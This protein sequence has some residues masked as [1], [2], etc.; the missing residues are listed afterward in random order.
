MK[1]E[2]D[3]DACCIH[4]GLDA[5][6]FPRGERLPPC[7][8]WNEDTRAE[9]RRRYPVWDPLDLAEAEMLDQEQ[10]DFDD[11]QPE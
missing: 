3:H 6:D 10:P 9:N 2:L 1:H 8:V 4:C 7:P 11:F 5:C